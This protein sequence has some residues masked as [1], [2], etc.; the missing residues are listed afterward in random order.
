MLGF[1]GS[2]YGSRNAPGLWRAIRDHNARPETTGLCILVL[3]GALDPAIRAEL[4]RTLPSDAWRFA[5]SVSHDAVPLAM[6]P[7]HALVILQNNNN[8]TGRRTIPGKAFEYLATGRP[9]IAGGALDSDLER[10]LGILGV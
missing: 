9:L 5:G 6:S 4:E 1:F 2:L 8:E 3:Y 7:C 10:L